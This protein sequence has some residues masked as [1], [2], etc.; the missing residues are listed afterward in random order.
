MELTTRK[1]NNNDYNFIYNVKKVVYIKY[2]EENWGKWNEDVQQE[3]FTKFIKNYGKDI[4]I[5]T[6]NNTPVGFFHGKNIDEK[7]YEL[8]N[9]C[10]LPK[11]QGKGFGSKIMQD[12]L[13]KHKHQNIHLQYFK[14]NPVKTFYE[15]L[16]FIKQEETKFHIKMTKKN[17]EEN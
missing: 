13:E 2:V 14:Q 4:Q 1:Y 3:L 8:G 12:I 11:F 7:N 16:G 15:K 9:I 10:I 5:I 17:T 6:L